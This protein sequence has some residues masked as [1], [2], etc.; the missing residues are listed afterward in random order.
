MEQTENDQR[1]GGRGTMV[2]RRGK[3]WT[4]NMCECPTDQ[5]TVW[6]LAVGAGSGMGRGGQRRKNWDNCNIITTPDDFKNK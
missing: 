3:D 4:K 1:A 2:E 6:G 5:T